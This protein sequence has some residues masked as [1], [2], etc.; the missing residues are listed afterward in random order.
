MARSVTTN[1]EVTRGAHQETEEGTPDMRGFTWFGA[2]AIPFGFGLAL[3]RARTST[4]PLS[5]L[6]GRTWA[7]R[8]RYADAEDQ[9]RRAEPRRRN[10]GHGLSIGSLCPVPLDSRL[11]RPLRNLPDEATPGV[12][13]D[14]VLAKAPPLWIPAFAG[15][16]VAQRSPFAGMTVAQG[17]P[18][19]V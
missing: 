12:V 4:F 11:R 1:F 2:S 7:K 10:E 18:S 3:F 9:P 17:L 14:T 16:T 13:N 5:E 6:L 15:M 8:M 19:P